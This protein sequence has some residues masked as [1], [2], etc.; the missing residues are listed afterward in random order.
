METRGVHLKP[1]VPKLS[2]EKRTIFL[3][4]TKKKKKKITAEES[5]PKVQ[6]LLGS[7]S[8]TEFPEE[9]EVGD[10]GEA[11][12]G[13]QAAGWTGLLVALLVTDEVNQPS[14]DHRT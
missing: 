5:H 4:F 10:T 11:S 2:F 3:S 12:H 6:E 13:E 9:V 1:Q 8:P 14:W 7:S